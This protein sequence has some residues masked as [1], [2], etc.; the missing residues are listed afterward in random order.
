MKVK[1]YRHQ[2]V[3]VTGAV[4]KPGSYEIIGPRTLLEVLSLAGGIGNAGYAT[5]GG[6]LAQAGDVVN[7]IRKR[8]TSELSTRTDAVAAAQPFSPNTDTIVID[9]QRLVRGQDP[10]L[11]I[12]IRAGDRTVTYSRI[13][14]SRRSGPLFEFPGGYPSSVYLIAVIYII[15]LSPAQVPVVKI[16]LSYLA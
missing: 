1:E 8:E 14:G 11:N 15:Y 3:M 9:L 13:I 7:V 6:A 5:G 12:P 10:R 4:I 16:R 2:Q